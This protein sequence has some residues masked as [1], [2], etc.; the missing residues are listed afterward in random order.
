ML[1]IKLKASN[2]I[3]SRNK[4]LSN[5]TEYDIHKPNRRWEFKT[6]KSIHVPKVS[7]ISLSFYKSNKDIRGSYDCEPEKIIDWENRRR[8]NQYTLKS[9]NREEIK[10]LIKFIKT[11]SK[12][13]R[14][15]STVI[16][17]SEDSQIPPS[18]Y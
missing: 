6:L 10:T 3:S 15:D 9:M 4:S 8:Y 14:E 7:Q 17:K 16:N 2:N 1:Y 13:N 5:V 11:P 18:K 12:T